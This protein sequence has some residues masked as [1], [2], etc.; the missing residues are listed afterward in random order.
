M[1][2]V[3]I[4]E[5]AA[6]G[7]E[8]LDRHLARHRTKGDGLA[9]ALQRR[10]VEGGGER[11]RHAGQGEKEGKQQRAGQQDVE[12]RAGEIDQKLPSDLP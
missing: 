12:G 8:L 3:H 4:E 5:A 10:R 2:R 9:R 7:A 6:I 11:L 1:G